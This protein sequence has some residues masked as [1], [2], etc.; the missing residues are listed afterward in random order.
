V[1]QKRFFGWTLLETVI[2]ALLIGLSSMVAVVNMAGSTT[3]C[4][5]RRRLTEAIIRHYEGQV[6]LFRVDHQRYPETLQDLIRRPSYV[7]PDRWPEGRYCS[8]VPC[9]GWGWPLH[10]VVPGRK[11]PFDIFSLGADGKEGGEGVNEDL[12]SHPP[13]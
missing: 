9:D 13:R 10:Y 1:H 2:V 8:E 5:S 12:W 6:E 7:E 3:S 4:P 11:G